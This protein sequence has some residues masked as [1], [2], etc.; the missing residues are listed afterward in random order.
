LANGKTEL[1]ETKKAQ[2]VAHMSEKFPDTKLDFLLINSSDPVAKELAAG[3]EQTE[4]SSSAHG[5]AAI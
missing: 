5:S 2:L 3:R 1:S 4:H